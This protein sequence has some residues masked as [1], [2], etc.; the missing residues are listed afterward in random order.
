MAQGDKVRFGLRNFYYSVGT[1]GSFSTPKHVNGTVSLTLSPEG[2]SYTFYA[3]DRAFYAT[4][5]NNGYTG[6]IEVAAVNDDFLK[7]VLGYIED[8]T[9]G[10]LV[11]PADVI[12]PTCAIMFEVNG[13][14]EKQRCALYGVTFSRISDEHNTKSDSTEP[15]T[16]SLDFTAIGDQFTVD[17]ETHTITK[18]VS[19]DTK[20]SYATFFTKTPEPGKAPAAA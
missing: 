3:E 9:G 2:D 1:A 12:P 20:P 16:V 10:M 7:D 5:T 19:D 17:G 8:E 11:E 15:D 4:E 14:E 6:T 13:N 18:V